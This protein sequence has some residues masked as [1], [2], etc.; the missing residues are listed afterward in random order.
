ME[1]VIVVENL[2]KVYRKTKRTFLIF[3]GETEVLEALKGVSFTVKRGEVVGYLGPNGSGKSTTIKI[4]SGVLHPDE[5]EVSVLGFTPWERRREFL[6]S[7]GVMFGHRT[8]LFWEIPVI[9][10]F[11]FYKE[12]YGM[13]KETFWER[14]GRLSEILSIEEYLEKPARELSLGERIRCELALTLLHD[15]DVVLL[16][17]PFLGMDV[18]TREKIRAFLKEVGREGK[19]V[20]LSSHQLED[21][22]EIVERV[23]LLDRGKIV[24]DG[25]LDDLK[26]VVGWKRVLVTFSSPPGPLPYVVRSVGSTAELRVPREEVSSVV[27]ELLEKDVVDL[28]VEE[29]DLEEV[30]KHVVPGA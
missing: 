24:F 16:D 10:T 22:E 7:I 21:V 28:T 23:V 27:R 11:L 4:L 9:D 3:P 1:E 8:F 25:G 30:L 17:E 18:W 2:K 20:L 13:D 26:Q 14:V 5:G 29:P 12:A 15:P 19:T 6:E